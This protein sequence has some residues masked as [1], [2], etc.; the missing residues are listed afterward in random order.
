MFIF[1]FETLLTTRRHAEEACQKELSDAKR[2]LSAEQALLRESR[3]TRRRSLLELGR[4]QG[5][6]VRAADLAL[7]GSYLDRLGREIDARLKRVAAAERRVSQ[8]RQ[9]VVEAMKRRKV[10]EKLRE[11]DERE[12]IETHARDE[13][14]FIDEVATGRH[15]RG[16]RPPR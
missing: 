2:A 16:A 9:L 13:R 5:E 8:Q 12:F 10:L 11:K 6:G 1:R 4:R 3:E 7:F 14:K 15:A